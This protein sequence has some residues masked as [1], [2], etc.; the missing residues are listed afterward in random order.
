MKELNVTDDGHDVLMEREIKLYVESVQYGEVVKVDLRVVEGS[1]DFLLDLVPRCGEGKS[2]VGT[3]LNEKYLEAMEL[4][5]KGDYERCYELLEE[6]HLMKHPKG[7]IEYAILNIFGG[8]PKKIMKY[9]FNLLSRCEKYMD[10]RVFFVLGVCR[11]MG[12]GTI[13]NTNESYNYYLKS[14]LCAYPPAVQKCC[15]SKEISGTISR[16][17]REMYESVS[18]RGDEE[19]GLY[20]GIRGCC[21][22]Y[23]VFGK[24]DLV[25]G[26]NLVK[27]SS[28]LGSSF[29]QNIL[30]DCH[31]YGLG[32]E[33]DLKKAFE[34]YKV[35]AEGGDSDG[36]LNSAMCY[37]DGKG[38]EKD[39]AKAIELLEQSVEQEHPVS[40][41]VFG[42]CHL[43]GDGVER[44]EEEA[45]EMFKLS[46]KQGY[47]SAQEKLELL[48][49]KL[50]S[51]SQDL[52]IPA[53]R[54]K[55][56]TEQYDPCLQ[57]S[58]VL[59]C[60]SDEGV[61]QDLMNPAKPSNPSVKQSNDN[62]WRQFMSSLSSLYRSL[63][64]RRSLMLLWS[65]F[66]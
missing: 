13:K 24:K 66:M 8:Y 29:G 38:V 20:L 63:N 42:L 16:E 39:E 40:Q 19:D 27:R 53:K 43:S 37:L 2:V 61:P 47:S 64:L 65:G 41:Y 23:G 1:D 21:L 9:G 26:F 11:E 44:D 14:L 28:D 49:D 60:V 31:Y 10:G 17:T 30:G 52:T 22:I 57:S 54:F 50:E 35:S 4:K 32:T 5:R 51:V 3:S 58:S 33:K 59:P 48:H 62:M 12:Y 46:A 36:Q 45:I 55:P 56:S 18:Q 7:T 6:L 25:E 34:M 15:R